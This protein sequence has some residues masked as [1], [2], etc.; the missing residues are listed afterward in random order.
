MAR[1]LGVGKETTYGTAVSATKYYDILRESLRLRKTLIFDTDS[2]ASRE[3]L[4]SARGIEHVEGDIEMNLNS[5]EIGHILLSL[6]GSVSTSGTGPYTHTFTPAEDLPSLTLRSILD[7]VTEKIIAGV[8]VDTFELTADVGKAR[9]V[10]GVLG[11]SLTFSTPSTP[12]FSAQEDFVGGEAI[13]TL[14]GTTKKPRRL[15]LR[16]NNNLEQIFVLGDYSMQ[17]PKPKKLDVTGSFELDF[18]STTEYND[19]LNMTPKDLEIT[20]TKGS[21]SIKFDIDKFYYTDARVEVRGRELLVGRFDFRAV[22]P[23]TGNS[24]KVILVNDDSSY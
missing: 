16:I 13:V 18:E 5:Q 24:I 20:F 17:K 12:T 19:F 8:V 22:K 11:K 15:T 2:V 9:V 3:V 10:V 6:L 14:A 21:H 1:G 23:E 7:A 4:K